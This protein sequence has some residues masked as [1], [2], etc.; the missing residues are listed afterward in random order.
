MYFQN[1]TCYPSH[2]LRAMVENAAKLIGLRTENILVKMTQNRR[3]WI[4]GTAYHRASTTLRKNHHVMLDGGWCKIGLPK[5]LGIVDNPLYTAE[6]IFETIIHELY[7]IYDYQLTNDG[8]GQPF[9]RLIYNYD[10]SRNNR[11]R[12]D[13]RPEEKRANAAQKRY[14]KLA[15]QD[16]ILN[17]AIYFEGLQ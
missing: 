10:G 6:K 7:H 15:D 8:K 4:G 11:P 2:L 9:S 13:D 16:V 17:L 1:K 5:I 12:H 3:S 14:L